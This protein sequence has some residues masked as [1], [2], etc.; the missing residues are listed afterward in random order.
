MSAQ[1]ASFQ[2]LSHTVCVVAMTIFGIYLPYFIN[3]VLNCNA[4]NT[5]EKKKDV[6]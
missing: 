5:Q 3:I 1:Y 6:G 2:P 4:N